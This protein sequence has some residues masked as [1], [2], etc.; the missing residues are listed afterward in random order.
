[1]SEPETIV[2]DEGKRKPA[3]VPWLL[4]IGTLGLSGYLYWTHYRPMADDARA[5]DASIANL[6]KLAADA[7]KDADAAKAAQAELAKTQD[8][9]K[10]MEGE[11][12]EDEKLLAQLKEQVA[13]AAEV[14]NQAGQITVTMVDRI[15]FKSGDATITPE[16]E[17]VLR[18]LGGV[19]A[20]VDKLIEV[21]GHADNQKIESEKK[22]QFPTNWELSV[23]RATNV[24]RF[25]QE[26]VGLKPRRLK[27]AGYGSFRPVASNASPAG[28][29]K[30]RRIEILLLPDK[31]KVVKG[32]FTDESAPVAES[33]PKPAAKKRR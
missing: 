32:D 7:K 28:R 11:K 4:F 27:A 18:K 6:T 5:K 22:A 1:V 16:G 26:K 13:G 15:L 24:V 20:S 12:S 33:H 29:A 30:N 17:G 23:A 2:L 10:K 8:Q 31:I 3:I 21:S 14:Q 25:L 19:L 9:V